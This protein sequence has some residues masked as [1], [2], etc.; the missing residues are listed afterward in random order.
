MAEI[1]FCGLTRPE[2]ARVAGELG[3]A[4][5]GAIFAGGPRLLTPERAA[6]VFAGCSTPAPRVGVFAAVN[7][8]E[9]VRIVSAARLDV[10][11]L[12]G[13]P[14]AE[15]V[16]ALRERTG[17]DVWAVARVGDSLPEGLDELF[18]AASA[19]LLDA[20]VDGRLGGT[21]VAIAWDRI[22][23]E[24]NR[25][26]RG[27]RLVLAGGLRPENVAAAIAA[28][29]PD[30][31]D[32]SSGIESAPGVKDHARMRAFAAAVAGARTA[33]PAAGTPRMER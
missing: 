30:V 19:V 12:H 28:L 13:D 16:A 10:A 14:T 26:R 20:K 8:E 9:I 6:V 2:D 29:G 17:A 24:L 27:R 11:Q 31:V 15:Q 7:A 32:V 18:D 4:Y 21:G 5:L 25:V 1:K 22:A 23:P 33:M 3:A